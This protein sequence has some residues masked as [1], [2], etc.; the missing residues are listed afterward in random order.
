MLS[1]R[2]DVDLKAKLK[3]W[4]AFYNMYRPHTGLRGKT[5]YETLKK[6]LAA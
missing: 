1:Y 4:E 5:P 3:D 6:K 2:G